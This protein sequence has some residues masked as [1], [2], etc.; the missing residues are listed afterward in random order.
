M[1][2]SGCGRAQPPVGRAWCVV[3]EEVRPRDR[4]GGV[5]D[6]VDPTDA[7]CR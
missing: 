5:D 4:S 7:A 1:R 3:Q 6:G 2:P